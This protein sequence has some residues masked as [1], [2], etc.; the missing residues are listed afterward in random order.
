MQKFLDLSFRSLAGQKDRVSMVK[1]KTE[2]CVLHTPVVKINPREMALALDM[3][4]GGVVL[5]LDLICRRGSEC[6]MNQ[7]I[8]FKKKT[9]ICEQK[10]CVS[11]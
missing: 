10:T 8:L 6:V 5:H 9:L 1:L 4:S 2:K 3:L 7:K 11:G